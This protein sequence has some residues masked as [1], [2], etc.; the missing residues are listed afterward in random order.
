MDVRGLEGMRL[1]G[2]AMCA[3]C[4]HTTW[5]LDGTPEALEKMQ[6]FMAQEHGDELKIGLAKK[7]I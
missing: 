4:S 7:T 2:G 6:D 3:G 5:V 1:A